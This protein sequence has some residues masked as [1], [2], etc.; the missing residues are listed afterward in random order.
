MAVTE[1]LRP[2]QVEMAVEVMELH[3]LQPRL[4]ELL[5]LVEEEVMD[6]ILLERHNL[7]VMEV[8][9]LL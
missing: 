5:I 6:G 1:L 3:S 8:P 2:E 9:V 4:L 7:P